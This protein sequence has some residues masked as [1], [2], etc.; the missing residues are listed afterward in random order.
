[1]A[2]RKDEKEQRRQERLEAERTAD[3][4]ARRKKMLTLLG[5]VAAA[6]VVVVVALIVVSQSGKEDNAS[7]GG[8]V[9]TNSTITAVDNLD[10][11]GTV[12]GD[13]SAK[14]KIVEFGDLQCPACKQFSDTSIP[15]LL[16]GPVAGGDA[17]IEFKNYVI[18]GPESETA[19]KASLAASEQ[20]R[21]WQFV[22]LFYANQG[23]ENSGYVTDDFLTDIATAAGV[24]D[25]DAWNESR[26]SSKWDQT[27]A[28]IQQEAADA[29]FTG[30]PSFLVTGPGGEQ[31]LG[32]F[33]PVSQVEAAIKKAAG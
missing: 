31:N 11:E 30:T 9:A 8:D 20:G 13:P 32:S 22:E 14:V 24:K 10:Q 2:S 28:D 15:K 17:K 12:L 25:L 26:E 4:A 23:T 18:I 19:A 6:A 1:M 33:P 3:A 21:Y 5:A 7:T 29:R 16:A 27:L